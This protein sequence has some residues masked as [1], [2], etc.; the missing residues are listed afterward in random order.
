MIQPTDSGEEPVFLMSRRW[1]PDV[2]ELELESNLKPS[3]LTT[4]SGYPQ[5]LAKN[6]FLLSASSW[7]IAARCKQL[8]Y[9][10]GTLHRSGIPYERIVIELISKTVAPAEQSVRSV[11]SNHLRREISPDL[12]LSALSGQFTALLRPL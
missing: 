10:I 5:V 8:R 2:V 6:L 9:C 7:V 1:S 12:L 4:N 3:F 11:P